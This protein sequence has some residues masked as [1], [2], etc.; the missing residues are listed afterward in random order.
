MKSKK[1][2]SA[3]KLQSSASS[4]TYLTA[5]NRRND[6]QRLE[7]RK[8]DPVVRQHVLYREVKA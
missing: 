1:I 8:Y 7:I 6:S 3:I 4:H 2:R 5:K